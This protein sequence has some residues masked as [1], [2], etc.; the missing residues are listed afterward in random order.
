MAK[1]HEIQKLHIL[2]LLETKVAGC[3]YEKTQS[4]YHS[5]NFKG[6]VGMGTIVPP[7]YDNVVSDFKYM[8][9]KSLSFDVLEAGLPEGHFE[10]CVRDNREHV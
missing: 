8:A 9:M 10:W 6:E 5:R 4:M 7:N 3:H 2:K 1:V